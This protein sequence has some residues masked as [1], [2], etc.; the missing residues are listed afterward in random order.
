[1]RKE[2]MRSV[3]LENYLG[4][5]GRFNINDTVCKKLCALNLRCAIEQEQNARVEILDELISD[6]GFYLKSQ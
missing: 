2:L 1:M 5:F 3:L 4:C 6:S